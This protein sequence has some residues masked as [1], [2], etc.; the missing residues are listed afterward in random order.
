MNWNISV[1]IFFKIIFHPLMTR[2]S[3]WLFLFAVM[4]LKES[5]P[6][7]SSSSPEDHLDLVPDCTISCDDQDFY[8]LVKLLMTRSLWQL[9]FQTFYLLHNTRTHKLKMLCVLLLTWNKHIFNQAFNTLLLASFYETSKLF[10]QFN[11]HSLKNV[12]L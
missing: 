10:G 11:S 4:N 6:R 1:N 5:P 7:M 12:I 9:I 2:S 3:Q 8:L